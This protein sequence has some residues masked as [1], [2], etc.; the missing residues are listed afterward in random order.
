M[1]KLFITGNLCSDPQTRTV[2]N[3]N[4]VTSFTIAV[5]KHGS[6]QES[7]F[8]RCSAWGKKGEIIQRYAAKGKKM[9]VIGQVSVSQYTTKNGEH[10]ASLDVFV[11]DFEFLSPKAEYDN[12]AFEPSDA[13]ENSAPSQNSF[14]DIDN[15]DL[16]F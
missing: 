4:A 11:E 12:G 6:E 7:T 8:F 16:P 1:Q 5:N 2:S 9:L 13:D 10:R 15:S 14:P 3:G